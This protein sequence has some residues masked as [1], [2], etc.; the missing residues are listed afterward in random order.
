M[1]TDSKK[2]QGNEANTVLSAVFGQIGC[3][4][5][6]RG[7]RNKHIVVSDEH[8]G[9]HLPNCVTVVE[10]CNGETTQTTWARLSEWSVK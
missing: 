4:V 8:I 10:L 7:S 2:P 9:N 6:M 5:K 3:Y 1:Q